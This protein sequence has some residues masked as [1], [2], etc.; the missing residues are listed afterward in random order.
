MDLSTDLANFMG[1][2]NFLM[3]MSGSGG[4]CFGLYADMETAQSAQGRL[5]ETHP[6]WWAQAVVLKGA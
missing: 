5:A 4:T 6:G 1:S 3:S 2:P